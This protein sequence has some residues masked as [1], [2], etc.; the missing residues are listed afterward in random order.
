MSEVVDHDVKH[1]TAMDLPQQ[2]LWQPIPEDWTEEQLKQ[3]QAN[4]AARIADWLKKNKKKPKTA[5]EDA[6]DKKELITRMQTSLSTQ[7]TEQEI[8]KCESEIE[9][10]KTE[11]LME[12]HLKMDA[13]AFEKLNRKV[14]VLDIDINDLD[15]VM[16]ADL[17]VPLSP[18]TPLPPL[19]D[20]FK[21]YLEMLEQEAA[22]GNKKKPKKSK[23]QLEEE[24]EMQQRY[25]QGKQARDE[26][27]KMRQIQDQRLLKRTEASVKALQEKQPKRIILL[28]SLGEKCGRV[29][30]ENSVRAYM[31][32]LQ[33]SLPEIQLAYMSHQ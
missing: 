1:R 24:A 28:S 3:H 6:A 11:W 25:E 10:L 29:K 8:D 9:L 19:E 30:M 2:E 20:E 21:D 33:S 18:F 26:P 5:E 32:Q 16:R 12:N 22:S 4:E 14:S 15:V 17:D 23:K 7:F 13:A 27:W 31:G